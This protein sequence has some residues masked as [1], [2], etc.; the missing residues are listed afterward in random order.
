MKLNMFL[1]VAMDDKDVVAIGTEGGSGWTYIG[2][3]GNRKLISKAFINASNFPR[4]DVLDRDIVKAYRK[5]V[6]DCVAIVLTGTE[7]NMVWTKEEFN[8]KCK[9]LLVH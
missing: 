6:D 7:T 8:K 9:K 3:A 1:D 5:E 4:T 2:E